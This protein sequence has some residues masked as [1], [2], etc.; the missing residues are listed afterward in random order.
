MS[1]SEPRP[2]DVSKGA[3]RQLHICVECASELVHP[4]KWEE[5]SASRWTVTLRCPNCE[6]IGCGTY[7]QSTVD[8]FDEELDLGAQALMRD[9]RDLARANMR[10]DVE[11]FV[12]ALTADAIL[13]E[14]F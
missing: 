12:G 9:L 8:C 3:K 2:G 10:D 7:E 13:P 5:T 11:R 1:V 6:W 14:D 4:V